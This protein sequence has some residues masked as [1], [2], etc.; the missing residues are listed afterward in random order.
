MSLASAN[1]NVTVKIL[2]LLLRYKS[3]LLHMKHRCFPGHTL[4]HELREANPGLVKVNDGDALPFAGMSFQTIANKSYYY[5]E[6][7]T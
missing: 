4:A 7:R 6:E 2:L 3:L 5:E 1:P